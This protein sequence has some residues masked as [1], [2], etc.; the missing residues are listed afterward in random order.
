M[1]DFGIYVHIPFCLTRCDYCDFNA[2]AGMSTLLPRYVQALRR[3]IRTVARSCDQPITVSSVY[4]GGGT[5]SLLPSSGVGAVLDELRSNFVFHPDVEITLEANPGSVSED[6]L[7]D[8]LSTGVNRLSLGMQSSIPEE[9]NLMGRDHSP[10]QVIQAVAGARKAGFDN[11]NLDL[12]FGLPGQNLLNWK[13][14]LNLAVQ[15]NPEHLS[16]Y[17]LNIEDGTPMSAWV[18]RGL[19]TEP[20]EDVA[21]D[22]YE[23]AVGKLAE[24]GYKHYE[25]SNWALERRGDR[26][27]KCQHNMN[28]WRMG[29]YLGFGA[30]AHGFNGELRIVNEMHPLGYI[31][32]MENGSEL[33][34][35]EFAFPRTPGTVEIEIPDLE[36]SISE[37]I[38]MGLRLIGEGVSQTGFKA[39]FGVEFEEIYG[40]EIEELVRYGLLDKSGADRDRLQMTPKGILLGN[41]VFLRF[42]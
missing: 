30:G 4:L 8:L 9:L 7:R 18:N 15:L 25:I 20:D 27:W 22:L 38:L 14:T 35:I 26:D 32:K 31:E 16:L 5:P 42:V 37:Y 36:T 39:R 29:S 2:Y 10:Q 41:Q 28:Y 40:G 19:L 17:G 24:A 34:G 13:R 21:G 12:I 11:L 33:G 3:E 1:S 23:Y 6:Y